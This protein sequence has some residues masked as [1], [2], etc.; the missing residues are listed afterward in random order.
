MRVDANRIAEKPSDCSAVLEEHFRYS[1]SILERVAESQQAMFQEKK[2]RLL[3]EELLDDCRS[4]FQETDRSLAE[5]DSALL[6][7]QQMLLES[8]KYANQLLDHIKDMEQSRSWRYTQ[9]MRRNQ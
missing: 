7:A 3:L 1:Q 2:Q 6:E 4:E 9:W 5:T 8:R